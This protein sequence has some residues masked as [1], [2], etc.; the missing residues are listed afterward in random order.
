MEETAEALDLM[1]T[2]Y[3]LQHLD[4]KPQNIF[5]V[6]NHVK[7][8][9][10]GL[11]KDLQGMAAS[12]TG[13]VTPVYAAPETFDGW[14]SRFCDQYSLSIVYQEML[15]GQRPFTAGNVH[16]LIMQHVKG[17]PNLAPLPPEDREVIAR[18][19][20]K[21]PD[22]RHA[23]CSD[24]VRAASRSR[25][26]R[27]RSGVQSQPTTRA[28][29]VRPEKAPFHLRLSIRPFSRTHLLARQI[30]K[31]G[32][33]TPR[34]SGEADPDSALSQQ[35]TAIRGDG[36]LTPAV[37]IGLGS[38]GLG[39]YSSCAGESAIV[40][41]V[42]TRYLICASFTSIQTRRLRDPLSARQARTA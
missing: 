42:K 20:A 11:V 12:V 14:I 37:V 4:I 2:H 15:T 13:G 28:P 8:A 9:D 5:L 31:S 29:R 41:A 33:E 24:M 10:F 1:N 32:G 26:P 30:H 23:S 17:K 3:Q 35:V 6:Q 22:E 21:V 16:Q 27:A 36:V 39:A 18:A 40:S 7:V 34:E 19:L 38:A 25:L